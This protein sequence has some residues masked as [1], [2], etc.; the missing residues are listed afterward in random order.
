MNLNY[1]N[2]VYNTVAQ[3]NEKKYNCSVPFHPPTESKVTGKDIEICRDLET[4]KHAL[5]Y[6][7]SL[8]GKGPQTPETSPC[9]GMDVFLG[10]PDISGDTKENGY[11][12]L[13][14]KSHVKIKSTILYYDSNTLFAELG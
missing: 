5:T 6:Y 2:W 14:V 3:M 10:P 7:N 13:Y 11:I 9:S 12:R 1:D 8:V 4:G